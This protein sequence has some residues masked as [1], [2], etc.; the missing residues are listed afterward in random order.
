M[1]AQQNR[2]AGWTYSI[3]FLWWYGVDK[4]FFF[5]PWKRFERKLLLR[6]KKKK[7]QTLITHITSTGLSRSLSYRI[8][9]VSAMQLRS[10]GLVST[11]YTA[12]IN[13]PAGK[14]VHTGMSWTANGGRIDRAPSPSQ[15]PAFSFGI[16]IAEL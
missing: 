5:L 10:Y 1:F 4:W 15:P 13:L 14:R 7:P 3:N 2:K 6:K 9:G 16:Y 12:V 8:V 11:C